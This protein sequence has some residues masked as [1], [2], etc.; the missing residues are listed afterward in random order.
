MVLIKPGL[1]TQISIDVDRAIA[2]SLIGPIEI[3]SG[4]STPG[5]Y[6]LFSFSALILKRFASSKDVKKTLLPALYNWIDSAVPQEPAPK[7]KNDSLF[8]I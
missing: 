5:K 3:P 1:L 7:T 2:S 4:T 8:I 6:F